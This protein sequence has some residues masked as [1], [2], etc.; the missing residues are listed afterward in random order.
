MLNK[1]M[2]KTVIIKIKA[3]LTYDMTTMTNLV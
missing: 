2:T 3:K 1:A